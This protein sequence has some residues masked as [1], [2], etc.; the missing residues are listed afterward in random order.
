MDYP[1]K[2]NSLKTKSLLVPPTIPFIRIALLRLVDFLV[3]MWRLK[4]F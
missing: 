3:K 4:A 1:F 2:R